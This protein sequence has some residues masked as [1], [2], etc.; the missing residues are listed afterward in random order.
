MDDGET[1][2][3]LSSRKVKTIRICKKEIEND[4]RKIEGLVNEL[5]TSVTAERFAEIVIIIKRIN[6][7]IEHC[8][9]VIYDSWKVLLTLREE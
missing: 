4:N 1:N 2:Y 8:N 7:D 6:D 3:T 5:F 9:R